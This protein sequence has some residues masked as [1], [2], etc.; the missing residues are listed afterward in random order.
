MCL[1]RNNTKNAKKKR[2]WSQKTLTHFF[3]A[4]FWY[5]WAPRKAQRKDWPALL[6][7]TFRAQTWHG[8]RHVREQNFAPKAWDSTPAVPFLSVCSEPEFRTTAQI[9][10]QSL[11][12]RLRVTLRQP[13]QLTNWWIT[14]PGIMLSDWFPKVTMNIFLFG[15][16]NSVI[17][18]ALGF[19]WQPYPR[20]MT[21][22]DEVLVMSQQFHCPL[23]SFLI[24]LK[25]STLLWWVKFCDLI[26][27]LFCMIISPRHG[28]WLVA[29]KQ[30][31]PATLGLQNALV[32]MW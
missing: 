29:H 31:R 6:W 4:V 26:G 2:F 22:D 18:L 24:G 1:V 28:I 10:G 9:C 23:S 13:R 32:K 12:R 7:G 8:F 3:S 20:W 16:P 19:V 5:N 21:H 14:S 30:N 15:E 25:I 27:S 17:W 11:I